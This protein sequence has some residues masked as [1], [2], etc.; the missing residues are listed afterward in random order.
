MKMLIFIFLI[1]YTPDAIR[2]ILELLKNF[3]LNA[4]IVTFLSG[5]HIIRMKMVKNSYFYK[6]YFLCLNLFKKYAIIKI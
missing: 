4:G 5:I 2:R 3:G 1:G 6:I